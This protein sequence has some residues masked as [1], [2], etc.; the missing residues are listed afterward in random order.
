MAMK[1]A[2]KFGLNTAVCP[3]SSSSSS[4]PLTARAPAHAPL[5]L[6][7]GSR[8]GRR[9]RR[10]ICQTQETSHL[11]SVAPPPAPHVAVPAAA[12][13]APRVSQSF[14][15]QTHRQSL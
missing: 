12:P 15:A 7:P 9:R 8:Q 5:A 14:C 10:G 4:A 11:S 2:L 6:D 1:Q 13:V 3:S